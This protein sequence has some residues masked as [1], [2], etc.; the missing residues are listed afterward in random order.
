MSYSD[1]Y[2]RINDKSELTLQ[3][4]AF[5]KDMQE[6]HHLLAL[7]VVFK[8]VD[9]INTRER[10]ESEYTSGVLKKIRRALE[11]NYANQEAAIP[12][13]DFYYFERYESTGIRTPGRR[14]PFHIHSLLPIRKAQLRRIWSYDNNNLTD[15]L[16]K[17]IT[18]LKTVQDILVEP[19][20][21]QDPLKWVRYI[22]KQKHI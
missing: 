13:E 2:S 7:T 21:D 16:L 8:P 12:F 4:S 9:R 1:A 14:A 3:W 15:R 19:I 22:T 20:Q 17:D 18:S 11:P 10:W 5:F 6:D